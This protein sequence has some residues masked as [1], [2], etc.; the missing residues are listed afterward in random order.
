MYLMI[1]DEA[2]QGN[3]VISERMYIELFPGS[4]LLK[5]TF[6]RFH[7]V[8]ARINCFILRGVLEG[9]AEFLL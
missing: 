2:A 9:I 5:E 8:I 6:A 7:K 4:S 3:A 1:H